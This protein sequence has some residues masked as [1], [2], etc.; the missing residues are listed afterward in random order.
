MGIMDHMD[1]LA[2][3]RRQAK[4]RIQ[5]FDR[6]LK[7]LKRR[8]K[9]KQLRSIDV[10]QDPEAVEIGSLYQKIKGDGDER[11]FRLRDL[12]NA[13]LRK[14]E[15]L[16]HGSWLA[17]LRDH[18]GVLGFSE[19]RALKLI[20]GA[21][22]MASNWRQVDQLE[23][24][25]TNPNP[26][27]D[28]LR[29][30]EEIKA[31][32]SS[33]FRPAYKGTLGRWNTEWFTP[34]PFPDMARNVM[35]AIDLDPA[36]NA[37]AQETIRAGVYFDKTLNGLKRHWFGRVWLNPPY[38]YGL[39]SKFTSKLLMEVR[40]GRVSAAIML[41]NSYTDTTWF[42]DVASA[43]D[44]ICFTY[45]RIKFHDHERSVTPTQGQSFFYFG[46]QPDNFQQV[47]GR[48]GTIVRPEKRSFTDDRRAAAN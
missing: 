8:R 42:H 4:H 44:A 43:A 12:G 21:Q 15:S 37:V 17:W 32:I 23:D 22:W 35:G 16:E 27:D 33:Q 5:V 28:E 39:I 11:A 41:T 13:L 48:V 7:R 25:L 14:K 45:G 10:I 3:M 34:R 1:H 30:A 31:A 47:F 40:A 2:E 26:S 18:Q 46:S 29:R 9:Q 20:D 24:I 6:R 38:A 19:H 36:S